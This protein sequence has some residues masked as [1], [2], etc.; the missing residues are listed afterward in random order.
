MN[1]K[2]K[3]AL[4]GKHPQMKPCMNSL[5]VFCGH[6]VDHNG[7]TMADKCYLTIMYLA[8]R[9]MDAAFSYR[10]KNDA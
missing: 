6:F 1:L 4:T 3:E 2:K 7:K 5:D 10:L 9:H 8:T